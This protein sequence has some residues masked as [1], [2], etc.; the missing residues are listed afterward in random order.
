MRAVHI[1]RLV[2]IIFLSA[3]TI[4]GCTTVPITG[5]SQLT[6][7][8][9]DQQVIAMSADAYK[10]VLDSVKISNNAEQTAMV[11]RVG[12]RIK[13]AIEKYLSDANVAFFS[14]KNKI[15]SSALPRYAL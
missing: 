8:I 12:T 2:I 13:G 11:R 10:E 1:T 7:L 4:W 15:Y 6:G 14:H 3:A 5:R 9:S